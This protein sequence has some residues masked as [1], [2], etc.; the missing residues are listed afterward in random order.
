MN[1]WTN[2][3]LFIWFGRID[4]GWSG[5]K[6]LSC[7]VSK[8]YVVCEKGQPL[9]SRFYEGKLKG[10]IGPATIPYL[11]Q[12][13]ANLHRKKDV[14]S[15]GT[16]REHNITKKSRGQFRNSQVQQSS[17]NRSDLLSNQVSEPEIPEFMPKLL[18]IFRPPLFMGTISGE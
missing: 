16:T 4:F 13:R 10:S 15:G 11:V 2:I 7:L 12:V 14:S 9:W 8:F 17:W 5:P 6:M 1:C 3:L 18:T